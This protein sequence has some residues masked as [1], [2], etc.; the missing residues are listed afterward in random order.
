MSV[1]IQKPKLLIVEGRDEQ[2]CFEAA[3][4]DHLGLTDIQVMP[5]G[6]KTPLT[7]NLTGL[8]ING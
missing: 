4:R 2:F 8:I 6:G 1:K 3:L 5:I 7:R